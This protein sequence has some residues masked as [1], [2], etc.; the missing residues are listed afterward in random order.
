MSI[1]S[2][3]SY[4]LLNWQANPVFVSNDTEQ[5]ADATVLIKVHIN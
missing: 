1:D 3:N 5:K 2:K 4:F